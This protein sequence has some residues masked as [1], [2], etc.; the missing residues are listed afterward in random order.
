MAS[1]EH[2]AKGWQDSVPMW[3][4]IVLPLLAMLGSAFAGAFLGGWKV[5]AQLTMDEAKIS[6]LEKQIQVDEDQRTAIQESLE[7][8]SSQL[9]DMRRDNAMIFT[10]LHDHWKDVPMI[11]EDREHENVVHHHMGFMTPRLTTQID[12]NQQLSN[13]YDG[14]EQHYDTGHPHPR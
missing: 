10:V 8:M 11:P 1:R 6:S 12:Q 14:M 5:A 3:L 9:E 2:E 7:R 13:G 4:K